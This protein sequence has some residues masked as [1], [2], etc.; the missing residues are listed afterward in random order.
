[1]TCHFE[2]TVKL[3]PKDAYAWFFLGRQHYQRKDY[4]EALK[5]FQMGEQVKPGFSAVNLYH[6]GDTLVHEG[7]KKEGVAVLKQAANFHCQCMLDNKGK[8]MARGKLTQSLK[9]KRED[10]SEIF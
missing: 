4:K 2:K 8:V 3:D 5:C 9:V 7:K 1:M 6:L 10:I